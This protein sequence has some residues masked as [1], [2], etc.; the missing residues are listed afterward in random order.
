[1]VYKI[2]VFM[3]KSLINYCMCRINVRRT[4]ATGTN[5]CPRVRFN[6]QRVDY[7]KEF[8]L[9]FGYYVEVWDPKVL[10]KS[11]DPQTESCIALYPT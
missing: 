10:S 6:V 9:G 4:K 11:S 1:M 2:P 7:R 5:I 3:V 8:A